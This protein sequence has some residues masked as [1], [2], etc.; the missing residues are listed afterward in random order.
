MS[1]DWL[2]QKKHLF[3]RNPQGKIRLD[4]G[5]LWATNKSPSD[6]LCASKKRFTSPL[7]KDWQRHM[8]KAQ[9]DWIL[10][11]ELVHLSC[12]QVSSMKTSS[13]REPR[14]SSSNDSRYL[15]LVGALPS[16]LEVLPTQSAWKM[17][18]LGLFWWTV[19]QTAPRKGAV[20]LFCSFLSR[21]LASYNR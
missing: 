6:P 4:W 7:L 9:K 1:R 3:P 14:V 18:E 10:L 15:L 19:C 5:C 8:C 13:E 21:S 11:W 12:Q 2:C 20:F 16:E 17:D